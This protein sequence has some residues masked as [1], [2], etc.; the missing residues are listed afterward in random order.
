MDGDA[1]IRPAAL[2][3][4]C[5]RPLS[6]EAVPDMTALLKNAATGIRLA[7]LE[8]VRGRVWCNK[9]FQDVVSLFKDEDSNVRRAAVNA[10]NVTVFR[11]DEMLSEV[12]S[13]LRDKYS[14]VRRA[15][16]ILLCRTSGLPD[17]LI[18]E[19]S[20]RDENSHIWNAASEVEPCNLEAELR[21][22]AIQE[23]ARSLGNELFS[24]RVR[25]LQL[26]TE[27]P[28]L[29]ND[30]IQKMVKL[31]EDRENVVRHQ[32]WVSLERHPESC[33]VL[34]SGPFAAQFYKHLLRRS[35]FEQYILYF[36][37]GSLCA[38]TAGDVRR[39]PAPNWQ[40][41]L[42]R[43]GD[44]RMQLPSE[45]HKCICICGRGK[46]SRYGLT[47]NKNW[48][49]CFAEKNRDARCLYTIASNA[50]YP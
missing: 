17:R 42:V 19:I 40:D 35:Y 48:G 1:S 31:L 3:C 27:L 34:F 9:P 46:L 44:F 23:V 45:F 29:P 5:E 21:L 33:Q 47:G 2:K 49:W 43:I 41:I 37:H 26:L 20:S 16:F 12:A 6:D 30:V 10:L 18:R 7:V 15:A 22:A 50:V 28:E 24:D 4:L 8:A 36:D 32:A 38:G 25:V 11:F 14:R 13:L 39:F